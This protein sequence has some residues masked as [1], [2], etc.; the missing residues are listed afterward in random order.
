MGIVKRAGRDDRCVGGLVLLAGPALADNCTNASKKY[1]DSGAQIV[2]GANDEVLFISQ[3]SRTG[4]PRASSTSNRVRVPRA[5]ALAWN[6]R[7]QHMA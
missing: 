5:T 6:G 7:R 2:F 3:G 1:A 4:S